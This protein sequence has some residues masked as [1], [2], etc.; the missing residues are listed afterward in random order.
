MSQK[1]Q[2]NL[3]VSATLMLFLVSSACCTEGIVGIG[4]NWREK[5]PIAFRS[6]LTNHNGT[7]NRTL[8]GFPSRR[9][10]GR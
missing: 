10:E 5:C 2:A 8:A 4:E 1:K 6:E 9:G 3:L 7:R